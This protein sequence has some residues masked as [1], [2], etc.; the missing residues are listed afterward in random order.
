MF[1]SLYFYV[2]ALTNIVAQMVRASLRA[3]AVRIVTGSS[4]GLTATF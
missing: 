3:C 1:I 2:V 4:P